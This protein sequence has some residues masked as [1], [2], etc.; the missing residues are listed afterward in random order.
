MEFVRMTFTLGIGST[1]YVV[2]GVMITIEGKKDIGSVH[3][4]RSYES[5]IPIKTTQMTK[6]SA[7]S[8]R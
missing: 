8:S 5:R 6:T 7:T 2:K 1:A 3:L 4:G